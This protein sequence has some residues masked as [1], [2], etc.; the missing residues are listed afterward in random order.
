MDGNTHTWQM[1]LGRDTNLNTPGTIQTGYLKELFESRAWYELIPD[2]DQSVVTTGYET[3][4]DAGSVNESD[5]A[6]A[7]RTVDG[8]LALCYL[9]THR[10]V[11]VHLTQMTGSTKAWWFDAAVGTS[12][13]VSGSPFANT[14]T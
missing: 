1:S 8:T 2:Q 5:H 11:T 9:P 12:V 13:I 6:T 7:A 14:G 3:F 4:T 10:T